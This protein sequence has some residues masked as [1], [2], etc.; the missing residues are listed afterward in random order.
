MGRILT[1]QLLFCF[2][3]SMPLSGQLCQE[4][5]GGS[6]LPASPA[7]LCVDDFL[8]I[9]SE[10]VNL[11]ST[12]T[13][14]WYVSNT[15]NYD[16]YLG[17]GSFLASSNVNTI[18]PNNCTATVMSIFV[19]PFNGSE[20]ESDKE[21]VII[22]S[23]NGFS[24]NSLTLDFSD[25]NNAGGP[26]S[27]D[28]NLGGA[29]N[30]TNGDASLISGCSNV[31]SLGPGDDVP[32]NSVLVIQCSDGQFPVLDYSDICDQNQGCI[33]VVKNNCDRGIIG[34]FTNGSSAVRTT[35]FGFC[36]ITETIDYIGSGNTTTQG[37]YLINTNGVI[38]FDNV[39]A[40]G[41]APSTVLPTVNNVI[42]TIDDY[43]F[44]V[45]ESYCN[46]GSQ[47]IVGI[48]NPTP[49]DCC[50]NIYTEYFEFEVTCPD[51]VP[52][53]NNL[54]ICEGEELQLTETG[55][56]GVSWSWDGPIGN[57]N[58]QNYNINNVTLTDAGTY[59]VTITD[60][61]M[62]MDEA[63]IMIEVVPT[64]SITMTTLDPDIC[65]GECTSVDFSVSGGSGGPYEVTYEITA[66][67]TIPV[68]FTMSG[69]TGSFMVCTTSDFFPSYDSTNDI[70]YIPE[71]ISSLTIVLTGIE[72]GTCDGTI[73]PTPIQISLIAPPD[74]PNIMDV[75]I[76]ENTSTTLSFSNCSGT[77]N[78]YADASGS[79][80]LFSGNTF[81]TPVLATTTS[82]WVAC[83]DGDCESNLIEVTIDI[84]SP[85]DAS[86]TTMQACDDNNPCTNNDM[87]TVGSDGSDC[88]PCAGISNTTNEPLVA[89]QTICENQSTTLIATGCGGTVSWYESSA[90]TNLLATGTMFTT[91]LL[92]NSTSYWVSCTENNCESPLI[93]TS[94][95][96]IQIDAM[97]TVL[98]TCN[99]EGTDGNALDDTYT[100]EITVTGD[101]VS[102]SWTSDDPSST[103]G[104][105]NV[106]TEF[107]PFLISDGSFVLNIIDDQS[108]AC[109]TALTI[110]PPP[111]CSDACMLLDAGLDEVLCIDAGTVS[112]ASDDFITFTLDPTGNNLGG[113]YTVTVNSGSVFPITAN[114][115]APTNFSLQGGSAG[116]G[117]IMLTI[118]DDNDPACNLTITITDPDSC[119]PDCTLD[120]AGLQLVVC[121]QNNTASNDTDD[122]ITFSLDP[123]GQN[124]GSNYNVSV[125][126]GTIALGVASY[127]A[128]T[129]FSLQN[130]SAG[131]GNVELTITDGDDPDCSITITIVDPGTCSGDC[132]ILTNGLDL[133]VCNNGGTSADDTD[134]FISFVLNPSGDNLGND[135]TVT[136]DIGSIS[137]TSANYGSPSSFTLQGGS[138]GGGDIT[139]T[140]TD[141]SDA[142]C[143]ISFTIV[144]PEACSPDCALQD[145]GLTLL[146]CN[147]N[148]TA[149]D[150]AD[151]F[152]T[153]NLDPSGLNLGTNY[154]VSVNTGSITPISSSYGALTN[155]NLQNG[156]ASGGNV[157]LTITDVDD[158]S[159]SITITI[160]DPGACSD[161]CAIGDAG[162]NLVACNNGGTSSEL[163][164]DFITF[165]L[166]PTGD[167]LSTSYTVSVNTGSILPNNSAYGS[168]TNFS[169]QGG[170]AGGGNV[171]LTITD[172][173][174]P[175][176][177]ITITII[178]PGSCSSDC[179]LDNVGLG[180]ID[181]DNNST[182]SD[183]TD[184][185]MTFNLDPSGLNLGSDYNV[186]VNTGSITP[187]S[188]SYGAL[189]NFNLQNGSAGGGDVELTIT[190]VDDP[191]CSITI[192]IVDPNSCSDDCF[193]MDSGLD[194]IQ[195][196]D[197]GTSTDEDDDSINFILNP[198][199]QNLGGFYNLTVNQGA[200]LPPNATYGGPS[201]FTFTVGSA[202]EGDVEL[203]I[204]DSNNPA[205]SITVTV[206]DPGTCSTGCA[207][208]EIGLFDIA[209]F[210]NST[211]ANNTDDIITFSMDPVG[212][213]AGV[214]YTVTVSSG[215]VAPT[216]S[217]FGMP[218]SFSMQGG[219]AGGG[220]IVITVTSVDEPS[221]F[222]TVTLT[223]PL[224][225][226]GGCEITDIGLSNLTCNTNGTL[227]VDSDD[228][229][230]F[231]IDPIGFNLSDNYNITVSSGTISPTQGD[232]GVI[233]SFMLQAGSA[234][235]G[236]II[237]TIESVDTP[238][239][240]FAITLSDPG[241]CSSNCNI[242]TSGLSNIF[243][244]DNGTG[245]DVGD[246][247]INFSLNPTGNDLS[248]SYTVSSSAGIVSPLLANFGFSENFVLNGG[249]AGGGDVLIT[250]TD[251]ADPSCTISFI[252][253][254]PGECSS[255]CKLDE[256]GLVSV[257]CQDN[258]TPSDNT[259]DYISFILNPTGGNL[260]QTYD[261]SVNNGF[262]S[263]TAAA[264]GSPQIF[265]LEIG[266]AGNGNVILIITDADDISCE[267]IIDIIDPGAC[268]EN[269]DLSLLN[270]GNV[271]CN[272]NNTGGD[273][274]DDFI[275]F[276]LDP[277]GENLGL[278]YT[279]TTS[280]ALVTPSSGIFGQLTN[281]Q[282]EAGSAGNGAVTITITS[283]D[284]P[285]CFLTGIIDDPN[286]CSS[287]CELILAG[288]S[289]QSCNN[290]GTLT[291]DTDDFIQ[292]ELNPNGFNLSSNYSITS[293]SGTIT[294]DISVYGINT[295]FTFQPGSAGAGDV[296]LTITDSG[297]LSCSLMM[298]IIDNGPCSSSCNIVN[299]NLQNIDCDDNNTP[300][301][302]SDDV[303]M[304]EISPE[305]SNLASS[306]NLSVNQGTVQP[307]TGTYGMPII[308]SLGNSSAGN[309]DV[310]ITVTDATD[311]SCFLS[312]I[313]TDPGSC[314][315]ECIIENIGLN[316]L[317]CNSNGTTTDDTDDFIGFTINPSG[318]N[319]GTSYTVSVSS[320]TIDVT[321]G[322]YG[323]P[324]SISM[325]DGSAG[326]GD[327]VLTVTDVNNP[328]CSIT[329][330]LED[331][332]ACS[333]SCN[334]EASNVIDVICNNN[335]TLS[336]SSDDFISF[337]LQPQG[338]NVSTEYIVTTINGTITPTSGTYGMLTLFELELGSAG[339]GDIV[340]TITDMTDPSCFISSVIEDPGSCSDECEIFDIG[341]SEVMCNPHIT[342][343]DNSDD[344]II[345][346]LDPSGFNLSNNYD[347]SV[348]QG[349][350]LPMNGIYGSPSTFTLN[351]G[352]AGS[353]NVFLTLTDGDNPDC[354]IVV[355]IEDPGACSTDC[356]F[357]MVN[358]SGLDCDAGLLLDDPSDDFIVFNL[359]IQATNVGANYA[360]TVAQGSISPTQGTYDNVEFFMLQ[361]GSAG[362]GD[363]ELNITDIDDPN[364]TFTIVV[365]DT[366][367]CDSACDLIA[368]GQTTF[369]CIADPT[370]EL[371]VDASQGTVPYTYEWPDNITGNPVV[372]ALP[373]S[374]T[375]EYA[376][377]VTDALD[378]VV[379]TTVT[380][381]VSEFN[382]REITSVLCTD[383]DIIV[384]GVVYNVDNPVGEE[385]IEQAVSC[386]FLLRVDLSFYEESILVVD[387][388]YCEDAVVY[389]GGEE[390]DVDNPTGEVYLEN[391][392][393][394]G[395]DS[396]IIVNLDFSN[397]DD[398][399]FDIV[400]LSAQD[401]NYT[402]STSSEVILDSIVWE[403]SS[404]LS[405]ELCP[406]VMFMI[407]ETTEITAT[408]YYGEN[409]IVFASI[410]LVPVIIDT[411]KIYIPTIFSPNGDGVN[412]RFLLGS[413]EDIF[414]SSFFVFDRWGNKVWGRK[415]INTNDPDASWDGK[416]NGQA[417]QPGVYIYVFKIINGDNSEEL[418][419]G[420]ITIIY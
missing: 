205:C 377:T 130:G 327:V 413:A 329:I 286:N 195:C 338:T 62:C 325:Q 366:G 278:S 11:P 87:E 160:I 216:S 121:N 226:S 110:N 371:M 208:N 48:V 99:S 178:D 40:D 311:P 174:N 394:N 255:Q 272:S 74:D 378:C 71:S 381:E 204:T 328:D 397:D 382:V 257:I 391:A 289:N 177:N 55:G 400:I 144:D 243:C 66:G 9:S 82:Y 4:F 292:F 59:T 297:N 212:S 47:F 189:T 50:D 15:N 106:S 60:A 119:S 49:E 418:I 185:F 202:G 196:F 219:S 125:D 344:Y 375:F 281:F 145:E 245:A 412:D 355:E 304:L 35:I 399:D 277:Q 320:G 264:Y 7:T 92:T 90:G 350:V 268:S 84:L 299:F 351:L 376:V 101:N 3:V 140:I 244:G 295:L 198:T 408:G 294:P 368:D 44:S 335:N 215:T 404:Q 56:D 113:S 298:T 95:N 285:G 270:L 230:S 154:N 10:G 417:L 333:T 180:Q 141:D 37:D 134:D 171:E 183:G 152:I 138:A 354:S 250:I 167:N 1:L 284:D 232:Y 128:L 261:V 416:Y 64:P 365:P 21:I 361:A 260:S 393:V 81:V 122:I 169:L 131:G 38:S 398:P 137:P 282:L 221:C 288:F 206:V 293:S 308:L 233:T 302:D 269:C 373:G 336:D 283:D 158:P 148:G 296:I 234:G 6:S 396:T 214:L 118:T 8:E 345:F 29:C 360:V 380:L 117:D 126:Q 143:A 67:I 102:S 318:N 103:S 57:E 246:D 184:D 78:W 254:D 342:P 235:A 227:G 403:G 389:F 359:N 108:T 211:S 349:G 197:G 310:I 194:L 20:G 83:A 190:D 386:D 73:D 179:S 199:G 192:T 104:M 72:E 120:G 43:V 262:I 23:G 331:P 151:D 2:M 94:V 379:E 224:S 129:N 63:S 163:G 207:I 388:T 363:I 116:S 153:F 80:L 100:F 222:E 17:Q 24:I 383:E 225:C 358:P 362:G 305:G 76:C 265:D 135:Y 191:A 340:I 46:M 32:P 98:P 410:N 187:I 107:G 201:T 332:G 321:T 161:E 287:S 70:A 45:T 13:V 370:V 54:Q 267:I 347:I 406:D 339:S 79:T 390:F 155:F 193:L 236:D 367:P 313:V 112:N 39:G 26:T 369:A 166:N 188:S 401:N 411:S 319:L 326:S 170:S 159:C 176:C 290:N 409:C 317:S 147:G 241:P 165:I 175:A 337:S 27:D 405:C 51:A 249:S 414:I 387:E 186:S 123:T 86:C 213:N 65:Y 402:L 415:N 162:L 334:I 316:N 157:E 395:C 240:D 307:S 97:I 306:Y 356:V 322:L 181:C 5:T 146:T 279:V 364:C 384:N 374:G 114:Y 372:I 237:I 256:A 16:P 69:P 273:P 96:I 223:D 19:N 25:T 136:V 343:T 280:G 142:A 341:L 58:N 251:S 89:P 36:G 164:D 407:S 172:D 242:T 34:S 315:D 263:P 276:D 68:T 12:S 133:V 132:S 88:I 42:S 173:N 353:G 231:D 253:E 85:C 150:E 352:S 115:G 28:I 209:C 312:A 274:T 127:G 314:S 324:L 301:D 203:T 77:S 392:S 419:S 275:S 252:V 385:I 220:D 22:S 200:V 91:P 303:I 31:I 247:F 124:I 291:D 210:D 149:S 168:P 271:S 348:N 14:D 18:F 156:S 300:S 238:G 346:S 75:S 239:C 111:P 420:E 53:A 259:D 218:T 93:E 229:I 30:W 217:T 309:G 357:G 228:F 323:A 105:F 330:T 248:A 109:A 33:Y 41:V 258:N 266:S 61:N 139:L 182:G 52:N